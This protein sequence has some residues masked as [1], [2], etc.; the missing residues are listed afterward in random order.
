MHRLR[1]PRRASVSRNAWPV[2]G[3][4]VS[5]SRLGEEFAA[6]RHT[7]SGR[8][9]VRHACTVC[10]LIHTIM[11]TSHSANAHAYIN[12]PA[13]EGETQ[14]VARAADRV[15]RK[16]KNCGGSAAPPSWCRGWGGGIGFWPRNC[17]PHALHA[18][19]SVSWLTLCVGGVAEEF[20]GLCWDSAA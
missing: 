9:R 5:L 2:V 16:G 10:K 1:Y 19:T 14:S 8:R 13:R 6:R 3:P 20:E 17:L 12:V 11:L 15:P 18:A 7:L 4:A